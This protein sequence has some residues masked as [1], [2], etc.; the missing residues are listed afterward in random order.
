M[1]I[2]DGVFSA[3]CSCPLFNCAVR[4]VGLY[5]RAPYRGVHCCVVVAWSAVPGGATDV[6]AVS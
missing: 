4:E 1:N 6:A 5:Y 3:L 2:L